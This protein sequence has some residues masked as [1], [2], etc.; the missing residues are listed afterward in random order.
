MTVRGP[1][2][3]DLERLSPKVLERLRPVIPQWIGSDE[4]PPEALVTGVYLAD[5][6]TNVVDIAGGLAK[7]AGSPTQRWVAV[8]QAPPYEWLSEL[9]VRTLDVPAPKF[10]ILDELLRGEDLSRFEYL[11][12]I[13][14]DVVLPRGFVRQFLG[15]QRRTGFAIA[16]PARTLGSHVDHPI[17]LQQLGVLARQTLF[18]EAGPVVSFHRSVFDLVAPFDLTSPMGWGYENVWAHRVVERG[19]KMGIIDAV[20]VDHSLRE[21]VAHYDWKTADQGRVALL[22]ANEHLPLDECFR[23]LDVLALEEGT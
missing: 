16:Q 7:E 1:V 9:T 8:G 14:D 20:P 15:L 21:P 13:D 22:E 10:E 3:R 23:V 5:Q 11:V 17:V 6:L 12:V 19:M 2:R 4:T 18:V